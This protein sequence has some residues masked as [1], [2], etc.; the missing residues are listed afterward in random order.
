MFAPILKPLFCSASTMDG[1]PPSS[2]TALLPLYGIRLLSPHRLPPSLS[3]LPSPTAPLAAPF[4]NSELAAAIAT[5]ASKETRRRR[6][7]LGHGEA[8][9]STRG[10]GSSGSGQA[11]PLQI[12]WLAELGHDGHG[13]ARWLLSLGR[14]TG[15]CPH[16]VWIHDGCGEGDD[17]GL[18]A[19]RPRSSTPC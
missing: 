16:D 5:H 18:R 7:T 14:A 19:C 6:P 3:S 12:W 9:W 17:G 13:G 1:W 2:A 15:R 11:H 8:Q 4:S 10:S